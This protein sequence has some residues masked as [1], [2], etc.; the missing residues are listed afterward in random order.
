[1][2]KYILLVLLFPAI[3][4]GVELDSDSNG[5][6]DVERGGTNT[7]TTAGIWSVIKS[8]ASFLD[9]SDT[10]AAYSGQ[11]GKAVTVKADESGLEF[12]APA[13][14][15]GDVTGPAS[16]VAGNFP[17]LDATGKILSDSGK[18]PGDF[19]EAETDPDFATWLSTFVDQTEDADADPT[20][21]IEVQDE[22]FSEANFNGATASGVSQDDFYDWAIGFDTDLD[23]DVDVID[24]T[25]WATKAAA[26][27]A[28]TGTDLSGIDI[29]DDTNLAGTANEIVLTGDTL[30]IHADI[31]RDSELYKMVA[32]TDAAASGNVGTI[33]YRISGNNSYLDVSMQTGA[34]TYA[35]INIV[36]YSW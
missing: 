32:N 17:L 8:A 13:S 11:G 7:Q 12:T 35:W 16:A 14:G 4:F 2:V 27:H 10:P 21:E 34:A 9:F 18:A 36:Q 24:A 30:S 3:A 6:V 28:H 1:M 31:A 19:L 33:R 26:S 29:S 20:N 23:G 5:A 15:S 22:A 25:V